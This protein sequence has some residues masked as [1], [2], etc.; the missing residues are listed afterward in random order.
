MYPTESANVEPKKWTSVSPWVWVGRHK[1]GRRL[2]A[3]RYY[4]EYFGNEASQVDFYTKAAMV[5]RVPEL[6]AERDA[7]V[8]AFKQLT[9]AHVHAVGR[10]R[11][12]SSHPR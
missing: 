3:E 2:W 5:A 7:L 6:G 4:G 11:L 9:A 1:E 10:C 12:T 8:A